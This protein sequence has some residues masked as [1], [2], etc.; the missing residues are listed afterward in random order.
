MDNL[1]TDNL[2][3]VH[4]VIK[5]MNL[6]NC[7]DYEDY[8]QIGVIGLIYASN[9]Y[10][11]NLNIT[12]STYAYVCI[13]NEILKYLKKN[14][15]QYL[16]IEDKIFD[17]IR[18]EDTLSDGDSTII[19]KIIIK[20]TNDELYEILYEKL[21][22]MEKKIIKMSFGLGCREYKQV[23]IADML[24]IPQ[25]KVSRIKCRLLKQLKDCINSKY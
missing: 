18:I 11:R 8:Y 3:L 7:N 10:N 17:E 20:E 6:N 15:S 2:N 23:E 12:F 9:T 22:D 4:F 1:I 25:Y 14:S 13:K 21:N 16:S 24:G 5:K 19:E